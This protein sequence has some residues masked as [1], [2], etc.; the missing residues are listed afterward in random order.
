MYTFN[1]HLMVIKRFILVKK[2]ADENI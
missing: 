1:K 2:I